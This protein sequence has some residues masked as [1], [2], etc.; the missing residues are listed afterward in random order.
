MKRTR[1]IITFMFSLLLL[2]I[3]MNAQWDAPIT[4]F[5]ET[6][7]SI[8]P[9]FVGEKE[10]INTSVFYKQH[11]AKAK[12]AP[13]VMQL[14]ANMPIEL[15]GL[16]HGVGILLSNT[17]VGSERNS[18]MAAQYTYKHKVGRGWLNAGVQLG[19]H[20]INFD[21]SSYQLK[22]DSVQNTKSIVANPVDKKRIDVGVGASWISNRFF[23][24]VG[25]S[26]LNQPRYYSVKVNQDNSDK[27]VNDSTMSKIPISYN[28]MV[29]CNIRLFSTLFE[30]EPM[31]YARADEVSKDLNAALQLSW[32]KKY[33]AGAMWR[34]D[35]GYSIFA[36]ATISNVSLRYAFDKNRD[37][38]GKHAGAN[39]E[40]VVQY[41]F[42]LD[43]FNPKP[44]PH[45]S[46][47]LL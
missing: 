13:R 8:N 9:S 38:I 20:D 4:Q 47:R 25:A 26:H 35:R 5:W 16:A 3:Q 27:S 10:Q 29:G 46:I 11:W 22:I 15:L 43:I 18:F 36:G 32:N 14:S 21:A 19:L 30:I 44:Q 23:V 1:H 42:D 2:S 39:H 17:D 33:S 24:G 7:S 34:A 40:V 41:S 31:I 12:D 37:I 28:L 6:K 45:K